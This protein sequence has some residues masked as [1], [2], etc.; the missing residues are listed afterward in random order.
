[1]NRVHEYLDL[2]DKLTTELTVFINMPPI[3][4][5]FGSGYP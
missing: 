3:F 1:M 4:R 5:V 2:K